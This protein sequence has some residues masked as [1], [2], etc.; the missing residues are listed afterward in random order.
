MSK[1]NHIKSI[2]VDSIPKKEFELCLIDEIK[3]IDEEH[4]KLKKESKR[5]N[6]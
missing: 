2:P 1:Y 6:L 3:R 5:S 4:E